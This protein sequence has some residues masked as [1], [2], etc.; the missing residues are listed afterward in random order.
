MGTAGR[1]AR[2]KLPLCPLLL[3]VMLSSLWLQRPASAEV[4]EV[5]GSAYGFSASLS[6]FD[7]PPVER[8]PVPLV[9][10]PPEGSPEPITAT[11]PE[12]EL[13]QYGPAVIV[14]A[15]AITVSTEGTTGGNGAVT[16]SATVEFDDD[17]EEQ[18]DPF[19]ADGL[20]ATCTASEG[21]S[22]GSVT[23]EAATLV[24]STDPD[25]GEPVETIDLPT[26]PAPNTTFGGTIDYVGDTFRIVLNEQI[27]EGDTLTVNAVHYYLGQN[28]EGES[29]DG[30][31]RG[32]AVFG[33]T[34]C[35]VSA[36]EP[37]GAATANPSSPAEGTTVA[38]G[39]AAPG[40]G[41]ATST[42]LP[43]DRLAIAEEID[44]DDGRREQMI[45]ALVGG[46]LLVILIL[47]MRR[48][49]GQHRR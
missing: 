10:L 9:T 22:T 15:T 14:E 1:V 41:E 48:P 20:F 38:V 11:D 33:Q 3:A 26:N 31:A 34:V 47:R 35:G 21:G 30:E 45:G 27:T 7:S 40:S 19:N 23:L 28:Q 44:A 36:S 2:R 5:T 6:L 29:V 39:E 16:S 18:L 25:T 37:S 42:T 32:E 4:S 12:G 46:G 8:E 43:E 24:T 17:R 13:A 49:T